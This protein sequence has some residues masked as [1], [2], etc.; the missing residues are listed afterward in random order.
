MSTVGSMAPWAAAFPDGLIPSIVSLVLG[1]WAKLP[2]PCPDEHETV[3]SR[4]LRNALR[5]VKNSTRMLPCLIDREVVEDDPKTAEEKGRIDIRFIHGYD[6]SVYF[7]FECKRLNVPGNRG[8]KSLAREYVEEGMARFV[9]GKYAAGLKQGG[10]IGFVM[11]GDSTAATAKVD[12]AIR[13]RTRLLL[14]VPGT[15]LTTSSLFPAEH[16]V[17]ETKHPRRTPALALH[18]VFLAV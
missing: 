5:Q 11:N 13:T 15:G 14:M 10:M 18:H 12:E 3:V 6:E 16:A 4:S 17:R 7:A 9:I 1:T 2:K 8:C